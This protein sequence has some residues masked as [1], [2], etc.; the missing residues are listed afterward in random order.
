MKKLLALLTAF[1]PGHAEADNTKLG[2]EDDPVRRMLFA[3]QS[4]KEQVARFHLDGKPGPFQSL[5]DASKLVDAGKKEEAIALLRSILDT[6][7]IETRT[8]LWVWSALRELGQTPD[9]K[10]AY[11]V[12][13]AIIEYPSGGGCDTLAGYVDGSARYLNF[14]GAA[15]FWDAEDPTIKA[16]CQ[17]LIDSTIPASSRAKPRTSLSLPKGTPQVTLLTRSGPYVIVSPPDTTIGPGTALMM[18][19]MKL[20][21]KKGEKT[22]G[23]ADAGPASVAG[24]QGH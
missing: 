23:T 4:L 2:S 15:I 17:A 7:K 6:P 10:I 12:L 20:S 9:P 3:S 13:G 19:L 21:K 24:D 14:S 16:M 18:E 5:A 8:Q 1:L 22:N 11:E